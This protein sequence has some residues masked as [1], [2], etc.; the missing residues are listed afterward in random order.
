L[1]DTPFANPWSDA[2]D[3]RHKYLTFSSQSEY[4]YEFDKDDPTIFEAKFILDDTKVV[5]TRT[6]YNLITLVSEVSGFADIFLVIIGFGLGV[7]YTS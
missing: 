2:P 1:S 3:R 5:R 7:M 6:V 4:S